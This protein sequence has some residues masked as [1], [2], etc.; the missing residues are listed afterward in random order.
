M[1]DPIDV[2]CKFVPDHC[3]Y[4]ECCGDS[5]YYE[6]G[7]LRENLE[8]GEE[9]LVDWNLLTFCTTLILVALFVLSLFLN[10]ST[11]CVV[12]TRSKL[13]RYGYF[14]QAGPRFGPPRRD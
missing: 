2:D 11:A 4:P 13:R 7:S 12:C 5:L 1:D 8:G 3:D 10:L 9:D 6:D 14:H